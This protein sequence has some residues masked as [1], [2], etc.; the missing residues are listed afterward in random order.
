M[1]YYLKNKEYRINQI[2]RM[3]VII[4]ANINIICN[5][6]EALKN[7]MGYISRANSLTGIVD[8]PKISNK[9]INNI[10]ES[11]ELPESSNSID[12]LEI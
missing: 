8:I 4:D 6:E 10:A 1:E 5:S 2:D 7:I 3:A 11:T 9:D 12:S